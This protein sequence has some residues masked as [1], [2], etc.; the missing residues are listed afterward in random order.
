M[1]LYQDKDQ[2]GTYDKGPEGLLFRVHVAVVG[3]LGKGLLAAEPTV[4]AVDTG[5]DGQHGEVCSGFEVGL[6]VVAGTLAA[7]GLGVRYRTSSRSWL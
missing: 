1:T 4:D 7:D 2:R 5:A 3:W 6:E